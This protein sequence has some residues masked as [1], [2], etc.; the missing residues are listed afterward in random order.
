MNNL[1]SMPCEYKHDTTPNKME[2]LW[3][4]SWH[5]LTTKQRQLVREILTMNSHNSN[6]TKY[7]VTP[8]E[9]K[10]K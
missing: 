8:D 4:D 9:L 5:K 10:T 2:T 3:G 7:Q 6:V 1:T